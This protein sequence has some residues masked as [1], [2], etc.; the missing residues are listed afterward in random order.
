VKRAIVAAVAIVAF[1]VVAAA[2]GQ[3]ASASDQTHST[4][5]ATAGAQAALTDQELMDNARRAAYLVGALKVMTGESD[6]VQLAG[7]LSEIDEAELA[8]RELEEARGAAAFVGGLN[9]MIGIGDASQ[10]T[11][12]MS[13]YDEARQKVLGRIG[14]VPQ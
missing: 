2:C 13:Y 11:E 12:D 1:G 6:W 4:A 10:L 9:L 8:L 5:E 3:G 14:L 7:S